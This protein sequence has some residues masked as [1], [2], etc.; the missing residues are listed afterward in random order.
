[1]QTIKGKAVYKGIALGKIHVMRKNDYIVKRTKVDDA[2]AEIQRATRA[3]ELAA[4][5][6]Q[7]PVRQGC[8]RGG[9]KQR[10]YFRGSPD[11]VRG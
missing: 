7:E 8:T 9:R 11:D 1:M 6:L 4:T 2:E 3:R 5:Q 10:C